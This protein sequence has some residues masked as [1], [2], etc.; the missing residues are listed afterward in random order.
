MDIP[1]QV[2]VLQK[3]QSVE[4]AI[5]VGHIYV[6]SGVMQLPVSM[7]TIV[8]N[9]ALGGATKFGRMRQGERSREML[10]PRSGHTEFRGSGTTF[11][12]PQN[13]TII[14]NTPAR[15]H[16]GERSRK[17]ID[18]GDD[19]TPRITKLSIKIG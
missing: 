17:L 18:L 13:I 6:N 15:S 9:R 14:S 8:G 1:W 7:G 16:L 12:L 10:I 3:N 4:S 11:E 19:D 2:V 5:L